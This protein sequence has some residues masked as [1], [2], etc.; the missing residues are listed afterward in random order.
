MSK[1]LIVNADDFNLTEGVTRGMEAVQANAELSPS[2]RGRVAAVQL[3]SKA[4]SRREWSE[5]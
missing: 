1:Y 3:W 5:V 4:R 2:V